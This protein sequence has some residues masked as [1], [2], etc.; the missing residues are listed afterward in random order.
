MALNL[1]I[2]LRLEANKLASTAP[3][4]L[5]LQITLPSAAVLRF[6]RN[7]DDIAFGGFT[8]TAYPFEIGTQ[9]QSGDGKVQTVTLKA[10]NVARA[11]TSYME[12]YSGLVGCAVQILLVNNAN[13]GA[14]YTALTLA[15]QITATHLPA[16]ETWI[17]FSLG[18]ENPMRRR[19]PLYA[20]VPMHCNWVAH[21]KGAE[22]AYAGADT[23]CTGTLTAC[24][25]KNNTAHFGG[26]PGITGAPRFV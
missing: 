17:E 2:A 6:V 3:W 9:G 14:D 23:T 8:W 18:A 5:L 25:A 1:P 24:T 20:A 19:F 15:Y 16:D 13:L 22:C 21:F 11:L 26:R 4:L 7:P 12:Q 10:S